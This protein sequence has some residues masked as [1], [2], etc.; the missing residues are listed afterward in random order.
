MRTVDV[1]AHGVAAGLLE[2]LA[3]DPGRLGVTVVGSPDDAQLT[4]AVAEGRPMKVRLGL[5][6]VEARLAAMDRAGVGVQLLSPW[7]ELAATSLPRDVAVDFARLS[8]DAMADLVGA[9]PDRLLA[10]ANLPLQEPVL[11]AEELRRAVVDLGM[12]GAEIATRPDGRELDD[13]SFDVVWRTAAEL[14]CALLVHPHR[15]LSGRNVQ[16]HFLNNLVGNP[17]ESTIAIGHLVFGGVLERHPGVR[18]C[19]VHGGGFAPYQLGRWDH[20]FQRN[21]RG[22]ATL[23]TRRPSELVGRI[24][25]DTVVHSP[26]ALGYLLGVVGEGQVVLGSDYPFEMGDPDPCRTVREVPAV[27]EHVVDAVFG[28]NARALLGQHADRLDPARHQ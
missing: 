22:A 12:V 3:A 26:N 16:R 24:W 14:D 20:A 11:A 27:G 25:F 17:A 4:V 15:S 18:F 6:D 19:F 10:L 1:H 13:E 8:N 21:A 28:G 5:V 9:H 7:M 23:L 2:T